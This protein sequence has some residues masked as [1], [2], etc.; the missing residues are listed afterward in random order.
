MTT[1][2]RRKPI[3]YW[4]TLFIM[5]VAFCG[6]VADTGA[7]ANVKSDALETQLSHHPE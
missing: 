2:N 7:A 1:S 5:L 4:V 3:L 6:V